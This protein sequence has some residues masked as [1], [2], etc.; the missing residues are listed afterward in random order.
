[1]GVLQNSDSTIQSLNNI[2]QKIGKSIAT[3]DFLALC[4]KL[5]HDKLKSKLSSIVKFV[6]KG[7]G[8][9]LII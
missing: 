1:M 8:K 3:Y 7:G 6:V 2:N 9:N 5:P 4:T